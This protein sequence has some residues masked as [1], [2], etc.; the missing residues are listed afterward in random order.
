MPIKKTNQFGKINISNEAI[1]SVAADSVLECYG[2]VGI[3]KKTSIHEAIIEILKRGNFSDGVFVSQD[4][5]N[6]VYVDV[7][8]SVAYDVKITEV[9]REVQNRVKYILEKTFEVKVKKVNVYAQSLKK[10]D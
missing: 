9:L 4:S 2:V 5:K 10:V 7:Y 1:A 6:N 3:S 8:V